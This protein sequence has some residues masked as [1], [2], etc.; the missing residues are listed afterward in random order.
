[1]GLS[2]CERD[3]RHNS[4]KSSLFCVGIEDSRRYFGKKLGTVGTYDSHP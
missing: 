3:T 1:M 2:E 4:R